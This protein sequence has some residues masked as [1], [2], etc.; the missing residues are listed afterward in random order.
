MIDEIKILQQAFPIR[1][2][3]RNQKKCASF[4]TFR[5]QR[6]QWQSHHPLSPD[7]WD[8]GWGTDLRSGREKDHSMKENLSPFRLYCL[9]NLR[10]GKNDPLLIPVLWAWIT[11]RGF[12][13]LR[14][15]KNCMSNQ[16][17][18]C[19]SLLVGGPPSR[20]SLSTSGSSPAHLWEHVFISWAARSSE[21]SSFCTWKHD[22]D[23]WKTTIWFNLLHQGRCRLCDFYLRLLPL[24]PISLILYL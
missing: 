16:G 20:E 21:F 24:N 13:G 11:I 14:S 7:L 6:S 22:K 4:R 8:T 23:A 19:S 15:L 17:S 5:V 9:Y 2:N 3:Q 10:L 12:R 18:T 1:W